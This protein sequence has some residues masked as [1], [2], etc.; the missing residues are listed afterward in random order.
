MTS[1]GLQSEPM[2]RKPEKMPRITTRKSQKDKKQERRIH[3]IEG[4]R[5]RYTKFLLTF[6][7]WKPLQQ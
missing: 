1:H 5:I 3:N 6:L 2:P 7:Y 4:A